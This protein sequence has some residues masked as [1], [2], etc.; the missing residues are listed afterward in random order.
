M[1]YAIA[2]AKVTDIIY[3]QLSKDADLY[4]EILEICR[5]ENIKTGYVLNAVGGLS[6]ARLSM[7]IKSDATDAPPGV[8]VWEG[9]GL[10]E[11]Q[12]VGIIGQT[13]ATYDSENISGII[14]RAG[15]PYLHI[16]ATIT[17][18]GETFMGHLIEGCIVRSL[19][20]QSHF[21]ITLAKTEGATLNFSVSATVTEKYPTGIP[22]HELT[23]D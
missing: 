18:A 16:H 3:A 20:E 4:N 2:R 17:A 21:T 1:V 5:R 15:E 10:I 13:I 8:R 23:Q 11:C 9:G 7:P 22:I 19:H 6:R 12:A 14:N